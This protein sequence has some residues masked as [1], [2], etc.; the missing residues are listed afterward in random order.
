MNQK[1]VVS[2]HFLGLLTLL[3]KFLCLTL[4]VG[5]VDEGGVRHD[6]GGPDGQC[7]L[8]KQISTGLLIIIT[9]FG[10]CQT[11]ILHL[12]RGQIYY[13]GANIY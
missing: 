9:I 6:H 13:G 7:A 8:F 2:T 4:E 12:S 3:V 11:N 10:I 1:Q 5:G